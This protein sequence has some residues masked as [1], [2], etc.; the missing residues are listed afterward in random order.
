MVLNVARFPLNFELDGGGVV[1]GSAE[2][3]GIGVFA[4]DNGRREWARLIGRLL[5]DGGENSI[6]DVVR[7]LMSVAPDI[8]VRKL[9]SVSG[10]AKNT[11]GMIQA[12][13]LARHRFGAV[14]WKL[15]SEHPRTRGDMSG[16]LP[17]GFR[18]GDLHLDL[19]VGW[20]SPISR[21]PSKLRNDSIKKPLPAVAARRSRVA[22]ITSGDRSLHE[23]RAHTREP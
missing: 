19:P 16:L 4:N 5:R 22:S 9:D 8:D 2:C 7:G 12:Y 23:P 11:G 10:G 1:R 14:P 20:P 6:D 15:R 21:R 18:A 13:S 17:A 3:E